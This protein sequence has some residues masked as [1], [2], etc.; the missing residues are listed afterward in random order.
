MAVKLNNVP[1]LGA[2]V[3]EARPCHVTELQYTPT[4]RGDSDSTASLPRRRVDIIAAA[5]VAVKSTHLNYAVKVFH[6]APQHPA[7]ERRRRARYINL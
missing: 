7:H 6:D 2:R 5:N 4:T 3:N 1:A